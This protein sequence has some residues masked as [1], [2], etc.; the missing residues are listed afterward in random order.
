MGFEV[1]EEVHGLVVQGLVHRRT[2]GLDQH[3]GGGVLEP[4]GVRREVWSGGGNG[5][6]RRRRRWSG[7][8]DA[9]VAIDED[10]QH[11]GAGPGGG[12]DRV[13]LADQGEV[14]GEAVAQLRIGD[15]EDDV[16]VAR[17]VAGSQFAEALDPPLAEPTQ[18]LLRRDPEPGEVRPHEQRLGLGVGVWRHS[19]EV[20]RPRS[21]PRRSSVAGSL[22]VEP[23]VAP[24][25]RAGGKG[26][27]GRGGRPSDR[28]GSG[29]CAPP[30]RRGRRGGGG[31][32]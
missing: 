2:E 21:L 22:R 3:L 14:G 15:A 7:L 32:R 31:S 29:S 25:G 16:A 8:L 27:S 13:T 20:R 10:A 26:L 1:A 9:F 24:A 4:F 6:G 19:G 18:D 23:S 28:G 30:A 12:Q 5:S 17:G 11:R